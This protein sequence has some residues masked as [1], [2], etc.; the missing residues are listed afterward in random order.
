MMKYG[1]YQEKM[2][3]KMANINS[4]YADQA[5]Y[6]LELTGHSLFSSLKRSGSLLANLKIPVRKH[7]LVPVF[8]VR[9]CK[10]V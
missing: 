9:P 2:G 4:E 8:N 10:Y 5:D 1:S 3:L 7:R 6:L